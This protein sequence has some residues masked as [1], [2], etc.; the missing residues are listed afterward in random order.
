MIN[1]IINRLKGVKVYDGPRCVHRKTPHEHANCFRN[2]LVRGT[3]KGEEYL[4][5]YKGE[6]SLKNKTVAIEDSRQKYKDDKDFERLTGL[7]WYEFKGKDGKPF[8][9][10]GFIDIEADGL[11]ADFSTMLSWA[12]KELNGPTTTS[13]ITK[14]EL[15]E[16]KADKRLV[17]EFI[18]EMSKYDILVSYYGTGYDFMFLRAK[19]LHYGFKFPGYVFQQN[20]TGKYYLKPEKVHWD[21]Y[22]TVRSRLGISRKSLD[23]ACDYLGIKGKTPLDKDIWR[24]AKYGDPKALKEVLRHNI[25]DVEILEEL[26]KKLEAYNKWSKRGL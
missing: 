21:V 2:G 11:K 13:V 20:N 23:A 4:K 7:P 26:F 10:I 8:Y 22:Y 16:G 9:K 1:K 19:A 25:A 5:Q 6:W 24:R 15:F 14:K 12:I 17:K 18:E 3:K